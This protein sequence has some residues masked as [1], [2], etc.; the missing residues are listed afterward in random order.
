MKRRWI[1]RLAVPAGRAPLELD[2]VRVADDEI[3][4]GFLVSADTRETWPLVAGIAVLPADLPAHLRAQGNVY[5]RTPIN[6]PRLAR[7]LLGNAGSGYVV[8]PFDEVVSQYRD[9]AAEPPEGYDTTPAQDH[10]DLGRLAEELDLGGL[11]CVIGAGVGREVFRL[12]E[13]LDGVLG[14]DRSSACVR[15]ARNIAVTVEAFFLPAPKGS[16]L[17]EIPLDFGDLTREGADFAVADAEALPLADGSMDVVVLRG[18]D[19]LAAFDDP[20]ACLREARRVLAPGGRL[21]CH[22]GASAPGTPSHV[23]GAW[24]VFEGSA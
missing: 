10:V 24:Q 16:G 5:R 13:R 1:D 14:F 8:V 2:P 22:E 20:A 7:F 9:L 17:K 6:D 11:G 18:G 15:R 12:C 3:V 21:V 4:E 23:V 19:S